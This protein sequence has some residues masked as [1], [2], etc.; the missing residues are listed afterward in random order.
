MSEVS[1]FLDKIPHLDESLRIKINTTTKLEDLVSIAK[2]LGHSFT[3]DEL[4]TEIQRL[5]NDRRAEID[6]IDNINLPRDLSEGVAGLDAL[7]STI[8]M[9]C[10]QNPA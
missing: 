4:C 6:F 5:T 8:L 3:T 10:D 9:L 2:Q 7:S 1:K